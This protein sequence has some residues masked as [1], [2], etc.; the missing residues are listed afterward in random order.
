MY[1]GFD[2]RSYAPASEC[3]ASVSGMED[4]M[5]NPRARG[6]RKPEIQR[7]AEE[8]LVT[9]MLYKTL[10]PTH[11]GEIIRDDV[12][13]ALSLKESEAADQMKVKVEDLN[14]VLN[15]RARVDAE[16]A[17]RFGQFCGN[18]PSLWMDMQAAIDV[19]LAEQRIGKELEAITSHAPKPEQPLSR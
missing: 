9:A 17:L 4:V 14:A 13:P 10:P 12:L 18:G 1:Y 2:P 16:W 8:R 15:G 11:P 3:Q 19:W 6:R 7:T 5:S